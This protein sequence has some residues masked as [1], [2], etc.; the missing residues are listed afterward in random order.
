MSWLEVIT[1]HT[2]ENGEYQQRGGGGSG[3]ERFYVTYPEHTTL[4]SVSLES[5]PSVIIIVTRPVADY[6]IDALVYE[7]A[8]LF[9]KLV[10]S[11]GVCDFHFTTI[12]VIIL[13][14]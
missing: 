14:N 11:P 12:N 8:Q 6:G 3:G 13:F 9:C 10:L 2:A 1:L 7:A 4:F 5:G